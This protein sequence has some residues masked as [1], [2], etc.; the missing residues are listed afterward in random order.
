VRTYEGL[1]AAYFLFLAI[2]TPF[3]LVDTRR[4]AVRCVSA[5]AAA[6]AVWL[7][8]TCSAGVRDWAP[9]AYIA[10]AYWI[11]ALLVTGTAAHPLIDTRDEGVT[12]TITR[13]ERWLLRSD[14][15]LRQHLPSVPGWAVPALEIAYLACYPL[16]PLGFVVV[17]VAGS[18]DD[19]NR[20]W[21]AVL[22]SGYACYGTLPWLQSR[23]PRMLAPSPDTPH[24]LAHFNAFALSR[25]SH[26]WNTFPSGH[27]AM[28]FAVAAAL[29]PVSVP[30]AIAA[31]VVAGGVALGAAAGRYHYGID[32]LLG[33]LV[34][35]LSALAVYWL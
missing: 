34:A 29:A 25:I 33:A 27:A 3:T 20:F 10:F 5:L 11:P 24:A 13:F 15:A 14:A 16:V 23:P 7:V 28:S 18:A 17:V 26:G 22:M 31:G 35:G 21:T 9:L 1:S 8:S 19:V 12:G 2:A 30:A 4:R 6:F 32:V